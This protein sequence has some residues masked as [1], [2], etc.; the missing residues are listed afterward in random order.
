MLDIPSRSHPRQRD[1]RDERSLLR[2]E[3][4]LSRGFLALRRKFAK[5]T[6][7][8]DDRAVDD[9]ACTL[10]RETI[11]ATNH[12]VPG[13]HDERLIQFGEKT[14]KDSI[15]DLAEEANGDV[16]VD[17]RHTSTWNDRT[18]RCV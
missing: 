13:H 10:V 5:R 16:P 14:V 18:G 4:N 17:R 1:V 12:R 11:E 8:I 15:L 6:I 9:A 2:I 7:G 3:P